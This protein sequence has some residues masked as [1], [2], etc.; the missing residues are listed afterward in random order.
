[1]DSWDYGLGV[2][3]DAAGDIR[4][5]ASEGFGS[6]SSADFS[7]VQYRQRDPGSTF[8]VQLVPDGGGTFHLGAPV[9]ESF[10]IEASA[11]LQNWSALS[12]SERQQ[13]LQPGGGFFGSSQRFFRL[14]FTE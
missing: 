14:V 5:L 8:R 12:E 10:Q 9:G 1:M 4:V 2:G 7:V 3:A 13:L 6:G 11:D